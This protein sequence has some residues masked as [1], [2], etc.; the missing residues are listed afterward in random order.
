M[1]PPPFGRGGARSGPR[2]DADEGLLER[3]VVREVEPHEPVAASR[4]DL[5]EVVVPVA[6]ELA[7]A[8]VGVDEGAVR[9]A[10]FSVVV[11]PQGESR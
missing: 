11:I 8:V 7:P 6:L 1:T 10:K 2:P 4:R 5:T 9:V 3:L